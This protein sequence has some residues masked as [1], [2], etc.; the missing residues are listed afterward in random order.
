M[1]PRNRFR[2]IDSASLCSLAGRYDKYGCPTGLPG[3]DRFLGS[4]KGLQIRAQFKFIHFRGFNQRSFS[5]LELRCECFTKYWLYV[6][7]PTLLHLRDEWRVEGLLS[8][9]TLIKKTQFCSE[10]WKGLQGAKSCRIFS[11]RMG[12]F[13]IIIL[14]FFSLRRIPNAQ[15]PLI[16]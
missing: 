1:E 8:A 15:S 7:P 11:W 13:F 5:F 16:W 2:R 6:L 14:L 9:T 10:I 3:W 12:E 4:L